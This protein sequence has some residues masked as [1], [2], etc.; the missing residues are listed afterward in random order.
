M[1][2]VYRAYDA[3]LGHTVALKLLHGF[4]GGDRLRLKTEFRALST[5]SHPNL[6]NLYEL[7]IDE[8]ASCISMEL[9]QGLDFV[10]HHRCRREE[11]PHA[12]VSYAQLRATGLQLASALD[13]LHAAGKLHR[14]V[15]PSNVLVT[16]AGRVVLLD[17]GLVWPLH[18]SAAESPDARIAGTPTHMAPEQLAGGPLTAAADWYALGVT[19]YQAIT[20]K[21][22]RLP[23]PDAFQRPSVVTS[24][25][26]Q[27][28]GVPE[29]LDSLLLR[30]LDGTPEARPG[31]TEIL[32]CL[33]GDRSGAKLT[34]A[35]PLTGADQLVGREAELQCLHEAFAAT[36]RGNLRHVHVLGSSGIGKTR[37]VSHFLGELRQADP[38][39]VLILT[40]RYHPQEAVTFNAVDG[41]VDALARELPR[42]LPAGDLPTDAA[43]Y[44]ALSRVF[45]VLGRSSSVEQGDT[46][47]SQEQRQLAF[48]ALLG[49]LEHLAQRW[50]LVIWMDDV[51]WG[52]QG[53][54]SAAAR[55]GAQG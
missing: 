2:T 4:T 53:E 41:W 17:F 16:A 37:L 6:V 48:Q 29:D 31:S 18:P 45:P 24:L 34:S 30:L 47:S 33:G 39:R 13:C 25:R 3:A 11:A 8:Q 44:R 43:S 46:S 51:Q 15:K 54:R 38:D 40:S 9:V 23:Q 49:I 14:D 5:I 1:G 52:D 55:A 19:L 10:K 27:G 36:T 26:A 7:V 32:R 12:E 21:I 20:G 50:R 28:F 42:R 22:P 35:A